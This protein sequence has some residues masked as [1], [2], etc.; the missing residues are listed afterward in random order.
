MKSKL[1]NS[2]AMLLIA[3]NTSTYAQSS[4]Q[5]ETAVLAGGC[6]WC[7]QPP[8]DKLHKEGVISTRAGYAGGS[9]TNPTY[10]EVSAGGTGHREVVE[11]VFDPKK[12]SFKRILNV[13]WQNIDPLDKKGQFCDKG[14]QYTSAVFAQSEAQKSTFE[15]SKAEIIKSKKLPGD[16]ATVLISG[17]KFYP[18]EGYHQD[19]Y[20]KNPIRYKYYRASCGRDSRLK[21]LETQIGWSQILTP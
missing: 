15:A 1:F 6:F 5:T 17:G 16:L 10:E 20:K 2:I 19:Y 12:I 7:M 11:V 18:A 14:E 9:K 13:F 3:F 21:A 4:A 8:F